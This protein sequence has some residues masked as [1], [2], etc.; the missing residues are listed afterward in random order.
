MAAIAEQRN[1]DV[2]S[3]A[4]AADLADIVRTSGGR[5]G[6]GCCF[7]H[8]VGVG[9][10]P[11]KGNVLVATADLAPGTLVL[12]EHVWLQR[13]IPT[14]LHPRDAADV[15]LCVTFGPAGVL[16]EWVLRSQV[17]VLDALRISLNSFGPSSFIYAVGSLLSHSC[18]PNA[19][20]VADSNGLSAVVVRRAIAK[21]EEVTLT[22][23][24]PKLL[25]EPRWKR[26][27]RLFGR[28]GFWCCCSRCLSSDASASE[29]SVEN[30]GL[31]DM[32]SARRRLDILAEA[33]AVADQ[34]GVRQGAAD[35]A[36]RSLKLRSAQAFPLEVL[37]L[38]TVFA[39]LC[40]I[41]VPLMVQ[42]TT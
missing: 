15:P 38:A 17:G 20:R 34:A 36:G 39:L 4:A 41:L 2:P 19:D 7:L 11:L 21:G 28:Y 10:D 40:A 6:L 24:R 33:A 18:L 32:P 42:L 5:R 13:D 29:S 26:R 35:V 8:G 9:R 37:Q 14:F 27:L 3:M 22:Y 1:G 25:R 12:V 30:S 16:P 23:L 31:S